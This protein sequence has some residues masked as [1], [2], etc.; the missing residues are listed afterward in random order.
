MEGSGVLND[1]AREWLY[2]WGKNMSVG[3]AEKRA[4][5]PVLVREVCGSDCWQLQTLLPRS[6]YGKVSVLNYTP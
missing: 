2:F 5:G 6:F 4:E 1:L 3:M